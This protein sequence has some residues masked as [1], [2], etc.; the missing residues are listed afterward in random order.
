MQ[1][2][3]T[4]KVVVITGGATGIGFAAAEAFGAEQCKVAICSRNAQNLEAACARLKEKGVDVYGESID[5]TDETSFEQFARNADEHFGRIDVWVNN[6]GIPGHHKMLDVSSEEWNRMISTNLTA[7]FNGCKLAAKY[8]IKGGGVIFNA[9]SFQSVFPAAGSGPYGATKAAVCSLTRTF[10]AELACYGIRVL[11]Y[12]PGVIETPMAKVD[13]WIAQTNQ[14]ANIPLP[15][16]GKPEDLANTL[17]FLAS[18]AASYINGVNIE[19]TGGKFC[20]QNPCFSWE[21]Q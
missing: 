7:V 18:D 4:G 15:R 5:I 13:D 14:Q 9:G 3:L 20:V 8:M 16:L 17:V 21:K 6:A 11:T 12:I 19:V 1:L 2:N 10:A